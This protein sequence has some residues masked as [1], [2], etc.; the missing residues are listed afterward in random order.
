MSALDQDL[1]RLALQEQLLLLSQFDEA[2]AWDL[3]TRIKHLCGARSVGLT[4]EIRR[5]KETL[6]LGSSSIPL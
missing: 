4:I 3:G 5:A 6:F 1:Q 2:V